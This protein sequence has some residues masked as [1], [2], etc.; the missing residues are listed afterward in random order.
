MFDTDIWV[1]IFHTIKKNKLRTFLTGFSVAWG[2]FM[3]IVLLAAGNGLKNGVMSNFGD[4]SVN[5]VQVRGGRTSIEY[6]G[7]PKNR[8][9]R[10]DQK[11]FDLIEQRVAEAEDISARVSTNMQTS[12]KEE[13]SNCD[14]DGVYPVHASIYGVKIKDGLGRFIND[15][16][17]KERRKVAVINPRLREVLFKEQNPI[18][19]MI[20]AGGL[21]F[22]VVGVY[23]GG[24]WGDERKAYIPFSTSQLLFNSGWGIQSINFTTRNINN[25]EESEAFEK[26][27]RQQFAGLHQFNPKDDKAI[28]IRNSLDDYLQTMG[29]FN[30]INLF[31]V[32]IGGMTLVAG[33]VGV[34]NIMLIS[35]R[36]RTKEFGIRKAL[37]AKPWSILKL[38]ILESIFITGIFGYIGML[39]GI[40]LSEVFNMAMESMSQGSSDDF[41]V[42]KNPTVDVGIAIKAMLTLMIAGVVSGLFPAYKAVKITAVEAMRTE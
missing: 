8:S 21:A 6:Q 5:S 39:G 11:D 1:E 31:V 36:E 29:I 32:V 41:S 20:I 35:V 16:D 42:F 3:L 10:L 4:R 14:F 37:G 18:G 26:R 28:R 22:K 33:I 7:I 30:G 34:S 2:I 40:G 15:I 23:E 9:I 19:E 25:L 13:S 38:I 24:D 12:F 27:L 17:M